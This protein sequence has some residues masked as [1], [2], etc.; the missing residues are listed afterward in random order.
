MKFNT[1][2]LD[3]LGYELAPNVLTSDDIETRLEPLYKTLHFQKGQL[4][5][6]TGIRERRYWIRGFACMKARHEPA[7]RR[8]SHPAFPRS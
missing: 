2:Y 3:S 7:K 4:E 1:V 5:M 8:S 6:I